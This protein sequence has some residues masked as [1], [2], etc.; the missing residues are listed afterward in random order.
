MAIT[1]EKMNKWVDNVEAAK[2][3][4]QAL[5]ACMRRAFD[6]CDTN[7]SG[8]LERE[9]IKQ[10]FH[11]LMVNTIA[12]MGHRFD[13]LPEENQEELNEKTEAQVNDVMSKL[14]INQDGK[15]TFDVFCKTAGMFAAKRPKN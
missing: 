1:V 6:F 9:E 13:D 14:D 3:D 2:G 15:I 7:K 10:I 12:N 5:I 11:G 4:S 8:Y